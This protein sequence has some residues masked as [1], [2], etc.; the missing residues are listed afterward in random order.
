MSVP[1]KHHSMSF[2]VFCCILNSIYDTTSRKLLYTTL[3]SSG[4]SFCVFWF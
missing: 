1:T 2:N 4:N 3:T